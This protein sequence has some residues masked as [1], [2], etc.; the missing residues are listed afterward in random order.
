M[1]RRV[2]VAL[3][4]ALIIVIFLAAAGGIWYWMVHE[5]Q[6]SQT[7]VN[8]ASSTSEFSIPEW[9]VEFQI[10]AVLND[11][12]YNILNKQD[13]A[14][15]ATFSTQSLENIAPSCLAN[16]GQGIGSL[17]RWLYS[18]TD[19]DTIHIG[20]YEY[21]F[22]EPTA[23]C[24]EPGYLPGGNFTV[25]TATQL[26]SQKT[27]ELETA[28]LNTLTSINSQPQVAT[29]T[30]T[31]STYQNT[32]YGISFEYPNDLIVK[33]ADTA[34]GDYGLY[35]PY[36]PYQNAS[37]TIS[38]ITVEISPSFYPGTNLK[39]AYF[40]LSVN[41]QLSK[42]QCLALT[43]QP[44]PNNGGGTITIGGVIF[45]WTRA[46]TA[47]AGTYEFSENYSG[48][49]N[50]ACY[51]FN[52]GDTTGNDVSPTGTRMSSSANDISVLEGVL[53]SVKFTG[54]ASTSSTNKK[55]PLAAETLT[56]TDP[57]G[58][59]SFSYPNNFITIATGA[60]GFGLAD[61]QLG[62]YDDG[63]EY[64]TPSSSNL[65]S[66]VEIQGISLYVLKNS[67]GT[68][69]ETCTDNGKY[70][71]SGEMTTSTYNGIVWYEGVKTINTGIGTYV[72]NHD[73]QTYQPSGCW[74]ATFEWTL[75]SEV[76]GD[77]TTTNEMDSLEGS[78]LSSV[79]FLK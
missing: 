5:V 64:V 21:G 13:Q 49:T 30:Q 12:V 57:A 70:F 61:V 1:K 36:G 2:S 10:P 56:Y 68:S 71:P 28:I 16:A 60:F 55:A 65:F 59:L 37:T 51:E 63:L 17:S 38:L 31:T 72:I 53:P 76:T 14:A 74:D 50:G 40:N 48:Y 20:E 39:G 8:T 11:L 32:D 25:T 44:G 34:E 4:V 27:N 7:S 46:E 45:N 75:S 54:L 29:T 78:V 47:A 33:A 73:F 35:T 23:N 67:I 26:Y 79:Q 3:V 22:I 43:S 69:A 19:T 62:Q 24:A 15:V 41:K 42:S 77:A 18:A 66:N 52:L 9:D 58:D 6:P